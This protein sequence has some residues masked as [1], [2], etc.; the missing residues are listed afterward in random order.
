MTAASV[1]MSTAG[2]ASGSSAARMSAGADGRQVALHIDDD[3]DAVL[4]IDGFQRLVDA[5]RAGRM[6]AARHDRAAAGLFH[7]GGDRL[8]IGRDHRFADPAA[9]ARRKTCT[10]IGAP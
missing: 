6:V 9:P 8:G 10:I 3:A 1:A 5:V 7:R 4:G 2:S